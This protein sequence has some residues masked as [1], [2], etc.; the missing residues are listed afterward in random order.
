MTRMKILKFKKPEMEIE[1][2]DDG[3]NEERFNPSWI[4]LGL[5]SG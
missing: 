3:G 2:D 5:T 4:F 1:E